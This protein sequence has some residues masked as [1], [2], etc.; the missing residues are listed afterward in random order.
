MMAA[1]REALEQ[2]RKEKYK[3]EDENYNRN[4]DVRDAAMRGTNY[5]PTVPPLNLWS[6]GASGLFQK[7]KE[8]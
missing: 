4:N 6:K 5:N 1:K 3:D 8:N 7:H 2:K